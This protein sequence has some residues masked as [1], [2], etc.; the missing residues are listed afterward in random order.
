MKMLLQDSRNQF[1]FCCPCIWTS[2][3]E[4]A[5]DFENSETFFKFMDAIDM[6]DVQ[7]VVKFENPDRCEVI[8]LET[9]WATPLPLPRP[10][11]RLNA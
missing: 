1:Y 8:P 11:P 4:N 2:N 5:F 3:P 9:P 7:L 10:L 6:H